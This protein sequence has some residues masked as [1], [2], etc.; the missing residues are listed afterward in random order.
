MEKKIGKWVSTGN[1]MVMDSFTIHIN[2]EKNKKKNK[3]KEKRKARRINR[4][5]NGK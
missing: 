2:E 5:I 3:N 4:I 1:G